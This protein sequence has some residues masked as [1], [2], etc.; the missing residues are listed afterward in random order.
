VTETQQIVAL[1]K[2]LSAAESQA[3]KLHEPAVL[4]ELFEQ[5]QR[6]LSWR[7]ERLEDEEH[8]E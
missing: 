8:E 3:R 4:V 5:L 1:S 7:L 6:L 2:A